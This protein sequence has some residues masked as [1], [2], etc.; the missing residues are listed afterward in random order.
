V[1]PGWLQE[2]LQHGHPTREEL[3][4]ILPGAQV[5]GSDNCG[6]W[7]RFATLQQRLMMWPF[8][9]VYYLLFLRRQDSDPPHRQAL[10]VWQK[11][12]VAQG[13]GFPESARAL[14][15]IRLFQQTPIYGGQP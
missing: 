7:L 13:P 9:G 2:H 8:T 15:L 12:K 10:L 14:V 6:E 1:L 3:L 11:P 5:T 4:E